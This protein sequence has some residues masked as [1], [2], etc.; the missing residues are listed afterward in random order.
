MI[1]SHD[2]S[3]WYWL[4]IVITMMD[5]TRLWQI[6]SRETSRAV[7]QASKVVPVVRGRYKDENCEFS[8]KSR[9]LSELLNIFWSIV[10][11]L[12]RRSWASFD[13]SFLWMD[14][15]ADTIFEWLMFMLSA[16]L[17]FWESKA[18][19]ILSMRNDC[20]RFPYET[21]KI[22]RTMY[23]VIFVANGPFTGSMT[24]TAWLT[25]KSKRVSARY[26]YVIASQPL[27]LFQPWTVE[28]GGK[29]VSAA[30]L[31]LSISMDSMDR[32]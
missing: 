2:H 6:H 17:L 25:L 31:F 26:F 24:G 8:A 1:E 28:H 10:R 22:P 20:I 29:N 13:I 15:F 5:L 12:C 18:E 4:K 9:M 27:K 16:P 14:E 21:K 11:K 32:V 19:I 30:L 7:F 23:S 3:G